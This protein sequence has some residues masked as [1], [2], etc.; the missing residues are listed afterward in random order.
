MEI[1]AIE[2]IVLE[3]MISTAQPEEQLEL[4]TQRE[5]MLFLIERRE[6]PRYLVMAVDTYLSEKFAAEQ[7]E[8]I[9]KTRKIGE[10]FFFQKRHFQLVDLPEDDDF[11]DFSSIAKMREYIK[12][13]EIDK[14]ITFSQPVLSIG[15]E[16]ENVA[17]EYTP[18]S[19]S[20][21]AELMRDSS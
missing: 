11:Y 17:F 8:T 16:A 4:M 13:Q 20:E 15:E 14:A 18:F 3:E 9:D 21:Y 1:N 12:R 5:N 10:R 6:S 19:I 2:G 7:R